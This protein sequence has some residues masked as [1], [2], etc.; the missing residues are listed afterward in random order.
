MASTAYRRVSAD[1]GVDWL[2]ELPGPQAREVLWDCCGSARWAGQVAAARPFRTRGRLLDY[3][4]AAI[5]RLEWIE[6]RQALA[7]FPRLGEAAGPETSTASW[8]TRREWQVFAAGGFED[9]SLARAAADGARAYEQRFG[10]VFLV[11]GQGRTARQILAGLSTRLNNDPRM[12]RLV[13]RAELAAITRVRLV[14]LLTRPARTTWPAQPARPG[15][16]AS[17]GGHAPQ[18]LLSA[19]SAASTASAAGGGS[20]TP[21]GAVVPAGSLPAARPAVD[22]GPGAG[23]R[24]VA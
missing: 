12:E 3:A 9:E 8:W 5:R 2:D 21:G 22:A 7:P 15:Y 14:T 1:P 20:G 23:L 4:D 13:V 10:Y 17:Q 18:R 11:C 19:V 16:R 6:V 24:E